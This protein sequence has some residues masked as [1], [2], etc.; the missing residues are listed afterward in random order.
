[1]SFGDNPIIKVNGKSV[2]RLITVLKLFEQDKT[3]GYIVTKDKFVLFQYD[4]NKDMIPFPVPLSMEAVAPMIMEWLK[5]ADYGKEPDHDGD[6]GK[7]WYCY[8]ETW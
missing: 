5:T 1:M 2:E 6:N 4:S 8:N 3:T 7:G